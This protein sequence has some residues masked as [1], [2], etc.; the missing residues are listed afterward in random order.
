MAPPD[1][2]TAYLLGRDVADP[3]FLIA[4]FALALFFLLV[5]LP[6]GVFSDGLPFLPLPACLGLRLSAAR[7]GLT[8]SDELL[9]LRSSEFRFGLAFC[10]DGLGFLLRGVGSSFQSIGALLFGPSDFLY[11]GFL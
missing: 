11:A 7:Y 1:A 9:D 3:L 10:A 8:P 2:I 6:V 4:A 5:G